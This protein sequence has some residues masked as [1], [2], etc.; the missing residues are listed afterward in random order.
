LGG[1]TVTD[2]VLSGAGITFF[3]ASTG[4]SWALAKW[5]LVEKQG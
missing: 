2:G 1:E 4:G 5:E 3:G